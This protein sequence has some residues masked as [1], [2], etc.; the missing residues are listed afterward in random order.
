MQGGFGKGQGPAFS[1]FIA[2]KTRD[3]GAKRPGKRLLPEVPQ[4]PSFPAIRSFEET[5]WTNR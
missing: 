4:K 5:P 1:D 2:A 3:F